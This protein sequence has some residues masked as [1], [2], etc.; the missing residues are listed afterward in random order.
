MLVAVAVTVSVM[1]V[2]DGAHRIHLQHRLKVAVFA[3]PIPR[4]PLS[5]QVI[6]PVPPAA[7]S[8]PQVHPAGGV[9]DWK[10]VFGGVASVNVIPPS[11]PPGRC[12]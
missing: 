6:V 10:V 7:G 8:V 3:D 1:F 2:P 4:V 12:W 9:I 11:R 5:V